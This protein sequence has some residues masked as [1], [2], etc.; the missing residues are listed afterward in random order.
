M[1]ANAALAVIVD[2]V[3]RARAGRGQPASRSRAQLL[4]YLGALSQL[5]DPTA[6]FGAARLLPAGVFYVSLKGGAKGSDNRS[7]AQDDPRT[8]RT[9]GYQHR[10]RF[11]GG[12]LERFDNRGVMKGDQFRFPKNKDGE[13]S[14]RGNEAL[15]TGALGA[16]KQAEDFSGATAMIYAGD[17]RVAPYRK[18]AETACDFCDYR[19]I[20]RF[21]PWTEPYR[22]LRPPPK[23][24]DAAPAGKTS[25][26]KKP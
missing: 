3:Q 2:Y 19:P 17:A 4:A 10:G 6:E 26:R 5:A 13:F 9:E 8:L 23:P 20:C 18:A 25:A 14:K 7:E 1:D 16:L 12:Q 15:P 21:D 24:S 11:D 22:V